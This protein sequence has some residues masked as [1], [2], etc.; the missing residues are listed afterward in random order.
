MEHIILKPIMLA[1]PA[2]EDALDVTKMDYV[3]EIVPIIALIVLLKVQTAFNVHKVK[4]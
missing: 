3:L 4:F 1:L 2:L